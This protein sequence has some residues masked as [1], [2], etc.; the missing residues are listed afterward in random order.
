MSI[1]AENAADGAFSISGIVT[2]VSFTASLMTIFASGIAIYIFFA[3]RKTISSLF[4]LLINYSFQLTLSEMK[5]KLELLNDYNAN[6]AEDK[7]KIINVMSDIVGQ[8]QGNEKLRYH[9]K[10]SLRTMDKLAESKPEDITE[11]RKRRIISET[12]ERLRSL[13]VSNIDSF[14]GDK[15]E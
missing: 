2:M 6:N 14:M 3:K 11:P 15:N 7:E 10:D 5:E 12:R 13:N 1:P 8:I 4:G 9:F